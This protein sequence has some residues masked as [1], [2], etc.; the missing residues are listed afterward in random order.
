M[1]FPRAW[2][3]SSYRKGRASGFAWGSGQ[4][5]AKEVSL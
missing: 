1:L 3:Y 4:L 2:Q 5:A